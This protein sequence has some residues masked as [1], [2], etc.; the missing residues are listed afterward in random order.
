MVHTP[1]SQHTLYLLKDAKDAELANKAL[2]AMPAVTADATQQVVEHLCGPSV[3]KREPAPPSAFH[4]PRHSAPL[5]YTSS[6][7][8]EGACGRPIDE[9]I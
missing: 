5:V 3:V 8:G 4:E 2:R 1:H 6:E 9:Q 7:S